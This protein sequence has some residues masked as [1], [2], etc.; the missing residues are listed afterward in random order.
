MHTSQPS[1]SQVCLPNLI[2]ATSAIR[3]LEDDERLQLEEQRESWSSSENFDPG[4]TNP[5]SYDSKYELNLIRM[6]N[7][8]GEIEIRIRYLYNRLD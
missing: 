6:F 4:V 1:C 5:S 8:L 3:L 2:F 7:L